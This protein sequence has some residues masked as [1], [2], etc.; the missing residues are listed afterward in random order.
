MVYKLLKILTRPVL[1]MYFRRTY[2]FNEHYLPAD[3]PVLLCMN[4]PNSFSEPCII[5]VN[6]AVDL[7]FI[8][9]GD[10]FKP[11]LEYLLY[12]TNQIPIFRFKDGYTNLKKNADSFVKIYEALEDN[13]AIVI[14]PEGNCVQEKHFRRP[15]Q[16]GTARMAFGAMTEKQVKDIHIVPVGVNYANPSKFRSDVMIEFGPA[17]SLE[18][19]REMYEQEPNKAIKL[20]TERIESA[21]EPLIIDLEN[22]ADEPYYNVLMNI[23]S[24]EYFRY[25]NWSGFMKSN[26]RLR[27]E[28]KLA[29][30]W[31]RTPDDAKEKLRLQTSGYQA[32]LD[33]NR[34]LDESVR[35]DGRF[36]PANSFFLLLLSIPALVG[37][38]VLYPVYLIPKRLVEKKV[39]SIEFYSSVRIGVSF[40][41][42]LVYSILWLIVCTILT[43]WYG[44]IAMPAL[45]LLS[46]LTL[47]FRDKFFLLVSDMRYGSTAKE[48]RALLKTNRAALLEYIRSGIR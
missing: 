2:M 17:F 3:K 19:Y 25:R 41:V 36:R 33:E 22:T 20:V 43:G 32:M 26:Q 47:E 6:V 13:N 10:V 28:I 14:F 31:N 7:H 38:I 9:R 30:H 21:M 39:K 40:F 34:L 1:L 24:N 48:T 4:H 37:V 15:L 35:N 11:P 12:A 46:Y 42:L 44:L 16:K 45:L 18:T 23:H 27:S 5:A 8:V 29:K